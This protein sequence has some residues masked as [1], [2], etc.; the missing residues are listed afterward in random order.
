MTVGEHRMLL[1]RIGQ[2]AERLEVL[3]GLLPLPE[4]VQGETQQFPAV[5][6]RRRFLHHRPKERPGIAEPLGR[7]RLPRVLQ[8][9]AEGT[10]AVRAHEALEDDRRVLH[11]LRPRAQ[12]MPLACDRATA[13]ARHGPDGMSFEIRAAR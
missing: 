1:G 7:E 3:D 11:P 5:G 9:P 6:Q 10:G 4:P 13:S 2:L 8:L 12:R